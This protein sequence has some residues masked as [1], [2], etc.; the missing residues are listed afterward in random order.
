MSSTWNRRLA[1]FA[2]AVAVSALVQACSVTT[3][4][5]A[6]SRSPNTNGSLTSRYTPY[7][8]HSTSTLHSMMRTTSEKGGYMDHVYY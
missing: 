3:G 4:G 6:P 1:M 7:G 5:F 2:V 8:N